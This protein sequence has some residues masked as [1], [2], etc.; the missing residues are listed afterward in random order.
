[1]KKHYRY[2]LRVLAVCLVP[3]LLY[4]GY[5]SARR[6]VAAVYVHQARAEFNLWEQGKAKSTYQRWLAIKQ[7][8]ATARQW[9]PDNPDLK[10]DLARVLAYR[11]DD[12]PVTSQQ[13][14]QRLQQALSLN[15]EGLSQRPTWPY[16]W[17]HFVAVKSALEQFDADFN[18]GLQNLWQY[19]PA[20]PSLL[21]LSTRIGLARW[22]YLPRETQTTVLHSVRNSLVMQPEQTLQAAQSANQLQWVCTT[23]EQTEKSQKI[24]VDRLS[25][26]NAG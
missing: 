17:G 14:I 3:I 23:V 8:Y 18:Q 4:L 12:D 21:L 25:L 10:F 5:E 11:T 20:E 2:V 9:E 1:M 6:F 19:G 22:R 13:W 15:I 24:C 16:A 26:Q 7:D